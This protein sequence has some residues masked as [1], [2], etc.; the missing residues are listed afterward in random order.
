MIDFANLQLIGKLPDYFNPENGEPIPN[1]IIGSTIVGFG[2][3]NLRHSVSGGG[4][5]VDYRPKYEAQAKRVVLAFS[6]A[7]MSI[8]FCG[9]VPTPQTT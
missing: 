4:L 7:G 6:D 8:K 1:D 3:A 9:S 2:T 5:I